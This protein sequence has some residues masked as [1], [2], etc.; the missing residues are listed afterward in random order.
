MLW[1]KYQAG[2]KVSPLIRCPANKERSEGG[3]KCCSYNFQHPPCFSEMLK[4]GIKIICL[5]LLGHFPRCNRQRYKHKGWK[6]TTPSLSAVAAFTGGLVKLLWEPSR[7]IEIKSNLSTWVSEEWRKTSGP[8][9]TP[10]GPL[11]HYR[12]QCWELLPGNIKIF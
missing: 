5:Y 6:I 3:L 11:G 4:Q 9:W 7:V 1:H 10:G 8:Y 2:W 12:C